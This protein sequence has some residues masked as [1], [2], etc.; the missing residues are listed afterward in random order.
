ML[1]AR[2]R[3]AFARLAPVR[4]AVVAPILPLARFR[5]TL[6]FLRALVLRAARR[7]AAHAGRTPLLAFPAN[8]PLVL[9]RRRRRGGL[10]GG[11]PARFLH[12]RSALAILGPALLL[13]RL[14]ACLGRL[15]RAPAFLFDRLTCLRFAALPFVCLALIG[16]PALALGCLTLFG[17]PALPFASLALLA[18]A[19]LTLDGLSFLGLAALP[20]GSL[21]LFGFA[22]LLLA[23]LTLFSVAALPLAGL[24]FLRPAALPFGFLSRLSLVAL[25][26]GGLSVLGT[27]ALLLGR[28]ALL[29]TALRF[30]ALVALPCLRYVALPAVGTPTGWFS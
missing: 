9:A 26:F 19:A 23:G 7:F 24:A 6:R 30:H 2:R 21:A 12:L 4:P 22:P 3:P 1:S 17:L 28:L 10:G 18:L 16:L 29:H 20:L 27:A 5:L 15:L 14:A 25:S 11:C 13:L 8:R